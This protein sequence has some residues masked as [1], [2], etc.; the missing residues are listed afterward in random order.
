MF[1]LRI[2]EL[3]VRRRAR[4]WRGWPTRVRL[5]RVADARGLMDRDLEPAIILISRDGNA[6]IADL[7]IVHSD[8]DF[9][10]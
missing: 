9:A 3:K 10:Q 4:S 1:R 2:G 8:P 5:G 7:G 6:W